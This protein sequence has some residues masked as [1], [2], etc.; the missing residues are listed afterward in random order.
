MPTQGRR[1]EG[2]GFAASLRYPSSVELSIVQELIETSLPGSRATVDDFMGAG[3]D[4]LAV[5]VEAEQF[6][7]KSLIEQHKMIYA[8]VQEHL[9]SGAIHALSITT[10]PRTPGASA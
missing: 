5:R 2:A 3:G 4:H 9:D 6:A 1:S 10:V 8:A 7:G